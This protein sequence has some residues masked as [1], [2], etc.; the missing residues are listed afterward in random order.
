MKISINLGSAAVPAVSPASIPVETPIDAASSSKRDRDDECDNEGPVLTSLK[1]IKQES[2]PSV[3]VKVEPVAEEDMHQPLYDSSRSSLVAY[4]RDQPWLSEA[5]ELLKIMDTQDKLKF[6]CYS[7][8]PGQPSLS[9]VRAQLDDG[10]FDS[11][12]DFASSLRLVYQSAEKYVGTDVHKQSLRLLEFLESNLQ[13]LP[14]VVEGVK[15]EPVSLSGDEEVPDVESDDDAPIDVKFISKEDLIDDIKY[16]KETA[17]SDDDDD[18]D[19]PQSR[20]RLTFQDKYENHP[21]HADRPFWV[22]LMVC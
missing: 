20:L 15:D 21:D 3:T 7:S 8:L 18:D 1:R 10:I 4:K 9:L 13:S 12:E 6:F 14:A 2:S 5:Q 19:Q 11:F 16:T 17:V 22:C